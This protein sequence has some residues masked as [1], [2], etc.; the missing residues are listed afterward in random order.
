LGERA[1]PGVTGPP[2]GDLV[3]RGE[4]ILP[5]QRGSSRASTSRVE[6][7]SFL[8][9]A[10][11]TLHTPAVQVPVTLHVVP[12]LTFPVSPQ[13]GAPVSQATAPVL[14][15]LAGEHTCP[16]VHAMQPPAPLQTWFRPQLWPAVTGDDAD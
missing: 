3:E 6:A 15:G 4:A 5:S 2:E 11:G 14:H 8:P 12:S 16:A 10:Q 9:V 13:T 1:A 7:F